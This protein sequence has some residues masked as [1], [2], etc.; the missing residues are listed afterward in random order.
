MDVSIRIN[1]TAQQITVAGSLAANS[2]INTALIT[3][4]PM[5][6]SPGDIANVNSALKV[7]QNSNR[8]PSRLAEIKEPLY[9]SVQ[10]IDD[11]FVY[12][13]EDYKTSLISASSKDVTLSDSNAIA[14]KH[15]WEY[16]L[17][18]G[19][20][21]FINDYLTDFPIIRQLL[22]PLVGLGGWIWGFRNRDSIVENQKMEKCSTN[23]KDWASHV[24]FRE[25]LRSDNSIGLMNRRAKALTEKIEKKY[26]E[27]HISYKQTA[28]LQQIN[29]V[30]KAISGFPLMIEQE[31]NKLSVSEFISKF[32]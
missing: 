6:I 13:I 2:M 21:T 30:I 7:L 12:A 26:K 24:L 4:Y 28:E 31:Q 1:G 15:P 32:S 27:G 20:A 22:Y 19:F 3:P 18:L 29:K 17:H 8:P 10:Q 11:L 14:L 23:R 5:I 9:P 25:E 16:A